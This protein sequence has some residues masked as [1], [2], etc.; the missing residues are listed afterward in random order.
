M[1]ERVIHIPQT[2]WE[3]SSLFLELQNLAGEASAL[4]HAS[5]DDL[6]ERGLMWVVVR[7]EVRF[8]RSLMAGELLSAA[9]WAMPFR[10]KMSQR[11]YRI[12]DRDGNLVI[13]AAALWTIVDRKTRKM[14]DPAVFSLQIPSEDVEY[15][16]A[17]PG[18]PEKVKTCSTAEYTVRQD[19]LD[20]NMHMNNARYFYLAEHRLGLVQPAKQIRL[21]RA[22]FLNEARL[23][24]KIR[25]DWGTESE[26]FYFRGQKDNL[27]C[28]EISLRYQAEQPAENV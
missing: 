21:V 8:E 25:L 24:E 19:D 4:Y 16:V 14:V 17:R 7:Y 10:H 9:T 1:Y 26:V 11:N 23:A 13:T 20:T 27:D 18:I 6:A 3:L 28:F 5:G 22:A 12:S 15:V 2:G